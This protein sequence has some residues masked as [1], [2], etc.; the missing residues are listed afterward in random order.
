MMEK[1]TDLKELQ[2]EILR[3]LYNAEV[4]TVSELLYFKKQVHDEALRELLHTYLYD[5]RAHITSLEEVLDELNATLMEEHCRT[6][7]SIILE[8]KKLVE[9]CKIGFPRDLAI[10]ISLQRINTCKKSAYNALITL[11]DNEPKR[12]ILHLLKDI[13]KQES[14]MEEALDG[15]ITEII[16]LKQPAL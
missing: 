3:D 4:L 16:N 10:I 9:K 12:Q 15:L 5:S 2:I 8:S 11:A 6:M 7:K 13:L 14:N 1:I